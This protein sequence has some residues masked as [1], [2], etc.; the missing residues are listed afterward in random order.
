MC[1]Y[2]TSVKERMKSSR[3]DIKHSKFHISFKTNRQL[4]L[5]N[6]LRNYI[7]PFEYILQNNHNLARQYFKRMSNALGIFLI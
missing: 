5:R 2:Y 4:G 7:N 6:F 3:Y 1:H